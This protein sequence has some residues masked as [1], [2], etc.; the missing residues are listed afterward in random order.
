[1]QLRTW[2]SSDAQLATASRA[3]GINNNQ[4]HRSVCSINHSLI[5]NTLSCSVT[6]PPTHLSFYWFIMSIHIPNHPTMLS[7]HIR[8]PVCKVCSCCN[9][10][11]TS[12]GNCLE[13]QV[14]AE[15]QVTTE[16]LQLLYAHCR[17]QQE[18]SNNDTWLTLLANTAI[19][20]SCPIPVS[21]ISIRMPSSFRNPRSVKSPS[22]NS[23]PR[24]NMVGDQTITVS[25]CRTWINNINNNN[26][27][28]YCLTDYCTQV[29]DWVPVVMEP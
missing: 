2:I 24:Y 27:Y 14:P 29:D 20:P 15:P 17:L 10:P 13:W 4:H 18:K 12:D 9:T 23:K 28:C 1:M 3:V 25:Q 8:P 21:N 6:H 26:N 16:V 11:Y 5:H 7:T 19:L 22:C